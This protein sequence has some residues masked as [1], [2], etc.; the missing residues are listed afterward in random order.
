MHSRHLKG[1]ANEAN[2]FPVDYDL[3]FCPDRGLRDQA[4]LAAFGLR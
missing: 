2:K 1:E 3:L 4:I